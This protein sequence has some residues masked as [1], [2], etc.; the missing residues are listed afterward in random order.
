MIPLDKQ[1]HFFASLA[2]ALAIYLFLGFELAMY[3]TISA[4]LMKEVIWD[5]GM[6]R[7]DPDPLDM[8]ANI[9][10][11]FV[12]GALIQGAQVWTPI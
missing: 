10:G 6:K 2:L 4:G 3:L 9:A 11:I 7:G 8:A 1:L 12:A 5:H